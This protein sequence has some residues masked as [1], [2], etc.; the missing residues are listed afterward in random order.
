MCSFV[1]LH[2]EVKVFKIFV[3]SCLLLLSKARLLPY[4]NSKEPTKAKA[5]KLG[6]QHVK[7]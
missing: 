2:V 5:K 3:I 1:V 7:C 4:K 6:A